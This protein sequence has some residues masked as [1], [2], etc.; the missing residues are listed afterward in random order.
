MARSTISPS[1]GGNSRP[2]ASLPRPQRYRGHAGRVRKLR[3]RSGAQAVLPGCLPLG[4]WDRK[5]PGSASCPRSHGQE[6]A[7]CRAR[8]WCAALRLGTEGDPRLSRVSPPPSMSRRWPMVLCRGWMPDD[9]CIWK[10]TFKLPPGTMLSVARRACGA[11]SSEAC[12]R[13]SGRGG[14]S[15]RSQRTASGTAQAQRRRTRCRA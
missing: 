14:R 9:H 2:E 8:R 15:P 11:A 3:H 12:G 10:G 1:C 6:A 4:I 7:L 13:G 5:R